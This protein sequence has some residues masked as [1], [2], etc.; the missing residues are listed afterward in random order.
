MERPKGRNLSDEGVEMIQLWAESNEL[1]P[2]G[3]VPIRRTSEDDVL[4]ASS[5]RRFGRKIRGVRHD[6]MSGG[7]EVSLVILLM[8]LRVRNCLD[9][10]FETDY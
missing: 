8:V 5:I 6:T 7:H 4:R 10:C 2:D 9:L 1:C 3:T